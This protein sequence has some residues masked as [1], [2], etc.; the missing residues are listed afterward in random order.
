MQ[1][2]DSCRLV[3]PAICG[4]EAETISNSDFDVL[5]SIEAMQGTAKM[6]ETQAHQP[7]PTD[8]DTSYNHTEPAH[9]PTE[10]VGPPKIPS[11]RRRIIV[12]FNDKAKLPIGSFSAADLKPEIAR[13]L[14]PAMLFKKMPCTPTDAQIEDLISR[15]EASDPAYTP[16]NLLTY[17][18]IIIPESIQDA[19]W[20]R[21]LR[22]VNIV[23]YAYLHSGPVLPPSPEEPFNPQTHM[24]TYLEP[25]P[26]G[27]DARFAHTVNGGDGAGQN[28]TD[29]EWGWDI[30]HSDLLGNNFE[31]TLIGLT[32]EPNHGT[33]VLGVI[34]SQN[35]HELLLGVTPELASIRLVGQFHANEDDPQGDPDYFSAE[36]ILCAL[37]KMQPGEVLLLEAQSTKNRPLE[38]EPM[39]FD[40]I[41]LATTVGIVV[42]AAAG[43]ADTDRDLDI[44]PP[45]VVN[46]FDTVVRDSG[47]II[48]ASAVPD[49]S[50]NWIRRWDG[51]FGQRI[52]CFAQGEVVVTLSAFG[53]LSTVFNKN[54]SAAAIIAGA[55]L[56]IQG[57]AQQR[58]GHRLKPLEIRELLKANHNTQ[59]ANHLADGIGVMPDLRAIIEALPAAW[60]SG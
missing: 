40:L 18:Q 50:N 58:Y 54:S 27:I 55:A 29:I 17:R 31:T 23:Q 11:A 35:N 9:T 51:C 25:A 12:K 46:I 26:T 32:N 44:T 59:S 7:D 6:N 14:D 48:V 28:L 24:Q 43:N 33:Q 37:L 8:T 15:A 36:V 47:A 34:A 2:I 30:T 5:Y 3:S 38:S 52:D 56:A 39:V 53:G 20:L 22:S 10:R 4:R 60:A 19:L 42:V 1:S 49:M 41:K 16:P 21:L 57:V 13:A 45:G